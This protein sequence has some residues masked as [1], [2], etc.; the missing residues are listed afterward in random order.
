[1]TITSTTQ[2]GSTQSA[3]DPIG[4]ADRQAFHDDGYVVVPNALEADHVDALVEVVDRVYDQ[5]VADGRI[6][7]GATL[8]RLGIAARDMAFTRLLDHPTTFPYAWGLLGWNIY[9]QH[10]HLDVNPPRDESGDRPAWGWH[11]DGWRQ[12]SDAE[13]DA[14]AYGQEMPRPLFSLKIAFALSD[15]SEPGR[16]NTLMLPGSQHSNSLAR[17][18]DISAGFDDPAGTTPLI[19]SP[20][21]AMVFDRRLWHSRSANHSTI[22][23]KMVFVSYTY[24]WIRPVD[25]VT[26]DPGSDWWQSLN[27][28]QRQLMGAPSF[29]VQGYWGVKGGGAIDDDIPLRRELKDRGLLDRSVPWLR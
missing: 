16:G 9:S 19:L 23:R 2:P 5:E 20:G 10:N 7:G 15:L 25:D 27:P 4:G 1:M 26:I 17:P 18:K 3:G 6:A 29:G 8:H 28:V 14:G 13:F 22:T 11:Q 21:D 12:N 24:R